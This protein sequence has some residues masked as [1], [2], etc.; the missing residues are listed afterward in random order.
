MYNSNLLVLFQKLTK[1]DLR[2]LKKWVHS[3]FFNQREDV[4]HLYEYLLNALQNPGISLHKKDI[5]K[6]IFSGEEYDDS[7]MRYVMSFLLKNIQNYLVYQKGK[8]DKLAEQVKLCSA[9]RELGAEKL[10]EKEWDLGMKTTKKSNYQNPNYFKNKYNLLYEKY[11]F[12]TQKTRSGTMPLSEISKNLENFFLIKILQQGFLNLSHLQMS[13]T[14]EDTRLTEL[15]ATYCN[16]RIDTLIPSVQASYY[17]YKCLK[18]PEIEENFHNLKNILNIVENLLPASELRDLYLIAINYSI[19]KINTGKRSYIREAFDLYQLGLQKQVFLN[20]GYISHFLYKNIIVIGLSLQEKEWVRNFIEEYKEF[21]YPKNRENFYQ[22]CLANFHFRIR[23]YNAAM[24]ILRQ[25]SFQDTLHELD[26]RRMLLCIYFE[27]NE[28][29]AL[30]SLLD[31]FTVFIRRR[32][33][34]LGSHVENYINLIRFVRKISYSNIKDKEVNNSIR[35]EINETTR[36]V[37]RTWLLQQ[38][39]KK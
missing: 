33:K 10:F 1:K 2:E 17:S 24:S 3:P 34:E 20:N 28:F 26:A 31:S 15:V 27:R 5:F 21:L 8:S 13:Q 11:E 39:N 36:L 14:A 22:Y 38:L 25:V 23:D 30:Y 4:I 32:K 18:E 29:D 35:Q 6:S 19:N 7:K 12:I 37:Q 9:L 16:S